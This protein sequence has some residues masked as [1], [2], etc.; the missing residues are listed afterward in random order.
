MPYDVIVV[1]AGSAGSVAAAELHRRGVG[2]VLVLEA[3]ASDFNP[4]VAMPLGLNWLIG[5]KHDWQLQTIPMREAGMR[6]VKAPRGKMVGGSGSINSMVW[7]RGRAS[8]FD[9]WGVPGWGYGDI[10]P[11]FE[12]VEKELTP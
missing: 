8:D 5:S 10:E 3:G 4:L 9:G 12:A 6:R 11:V 1:G 2:R 7:F